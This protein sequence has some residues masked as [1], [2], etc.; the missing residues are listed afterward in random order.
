MGGLPAHYVA[1]DSSQ[2]WSLV[3]FFAFV[4]SFDEVTASVFLTECPHR[5]RFL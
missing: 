2:A 1:S 3:G 4:V 5:S